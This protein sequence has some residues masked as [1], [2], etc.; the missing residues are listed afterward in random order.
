MIVYFLLF[1]VLISKSR[2]LIILIAW[3][4]TFPE[5]LVRL[6]YSITIIPI[7][8]Y[9]HI[10]YFLSSIILSSFYIG[11]AFSNLPFGHLVDRYGYRVVAVSLILLGTFMFLFAYSRSFID[12]FLLMLL[13]G[14]I[15]APT[16]IGAVK[17]VSEG[18]SSFRGTSIGILNT[19]GP[20]ALLLSNFIVPSFLEKFPWQLIYIY[21]S[22]VTITISIPVFFIKRKTLRGKRGAI[23]K[24]SIIA[25]FVR[26]FGFWGMWGVSSY[27]FLLV[28]EH[29]NL[30]LVQAGIIS[31]IFS[32][33]AIVSIP[34]SGYISDIMKKRREI[35]RFFLLL[36][37]LFLIVYPFIPLSFIYV[38]TFILGFIA[39]AYRTPLDTYIAE[40]TKGK[41]ATSM[42]LAN[43]ISQPSSIIVPIVIGYILTFTNNIMIAFVSLSIGPFVAA[44]LIQ[45]LD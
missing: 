35:S 32:I 40:I 20:L 31:G 39:F 7:T 10:N 3:L 27:L 23:N 29:F 26:F 42:G 6:V 8:G 33:G 16:Y 21:S 2:I 15:S 9:L 14:I 25:S 43:L 36:F 11:Y 45:M 5:I 37:F 41:E 38:F 17:L 12:A 28:H 24:K 34:I 18:N 13:M 44:F 22:M 19:V 4:I 1:L 30:N